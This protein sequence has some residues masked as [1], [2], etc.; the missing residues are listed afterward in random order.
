MN[1]RGLPDTKICPLNL[2]SKE[3]RLKNA[4][5]FMTYVIV[6]AGFVISLTVF[7]IE[8]FYCKW[9]STR[10]E[11]RR[12]KLMRFFD[13]VIPIKRINGDYAHNN[14]NHNNSGFIDFAQNEGTERRLLPPPPYHSLFRPP[15]AYS[16]NGKRKHINGREYWV[17]ESKSGDTTLVPVRQPSA[18]LFHYTN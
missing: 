1:E 14:N 15:F 11:N 5:L 18:L 12:I 6:G 17:V 9:Q 7:L 16:P 3:R 4:D 8:Y 13:R 2:G 10:A